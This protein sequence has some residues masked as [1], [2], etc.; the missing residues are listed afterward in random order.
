MRIRPIEL[1]PN[2]GSYYLAFESAS[3]TFMVVNCPPGYALERWTK[4]KGEMTWLGSSCG[5]FKP[6]YWIEDG[7]PSIK[8]MKK[9]IKGIK[10]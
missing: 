5:Y 4:I 3:N 9:E 2:D 6:D 8:K 7:L 10:K 1:A